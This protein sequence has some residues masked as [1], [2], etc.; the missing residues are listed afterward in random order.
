MSLD[1]TLLDPSEGDLM[2]PGLVSLRESGDDAEMQIAR[3]VRRDFRQFLAEPKPSVQIDNGRILVAQEE[4]P[5]LR[6]LG[7]DSLEKVISFDSGEPVR[8]AGPRRT[9]RIKT[10]TGNLY[11]KVHK[12]VPWKQRLILG[13]RGISPARLEWENIGSLQRSGFD[14]PETVAVGES[15]QAFG[16]PNES[17]VITRE[18]PG[19][20]LDALLARG[21]PNPHDVSEVEARQAVVR[22]LA[23]MVRRFHASGFYHRDLYCGHLIVAPDARWGRPFF[24]DLARVER[25]FPPRRRWL[26]KDLAALESSAPATVSRTDR[27]RF[28]LI[29]LC[30]SRLDPLAKRWALDVLRK[31]AK[32]RSHVPKY[33]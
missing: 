15:D 19:P 12:G 3:S 28:L 29:Y 26:V 25:R 30:K 5:L 31:S 20:P 7:L 13:R 4:L 24:I 11:L 6:E 23:G 33:G 14:L 16:V 9:F 21:W 1:H 27:L 32:I 17:F 22:D 18:V 10:S 2:H 8:E